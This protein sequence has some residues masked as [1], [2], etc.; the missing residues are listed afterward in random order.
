[1]PQMA[2]SA[3]TP[4]GTTAPSMTRGSAVPTPPVQ[5]DLFP[6]PAPNV[7]ISSDKLSQ[8]Q[9]QLN[10]LAVSIQHLHLKLDYLH[11]TMPRTPPTSAE[12]ANPFI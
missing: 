5:P 2:P 8:V 7:D 1:M 11:A 3:A 9:T 10:A 12:R 6:V 4:T